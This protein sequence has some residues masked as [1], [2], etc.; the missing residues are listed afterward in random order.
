M[1]SMLNI[2]NDHL[3]Q[4]ACCP[5][6]HCF[7]TQPVQALAQNAD[8]STDLKANRKSLH[9]MICSRFM[10]AHMNPGLEYMPDTTIYPFLSSARV[11][12]I[13]T[14]IYTY[15]CPLLIIDIYEWRAE[16]TLEVCCWLAEPVCYRIWAM[17]D[18]SYTR[19]VAQVD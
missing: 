10:H 2:A 12:D 11:F 7:Y 13:G 6:I 8:M 9:H 14:C 19:V 3:M 1:K 5:K 16:E 18:R 4:N 15:I 17:R